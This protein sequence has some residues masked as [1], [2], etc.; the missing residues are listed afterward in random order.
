MVIRG[1][2]AADSAELVELLVAAELAVRGV[3]ERGVAGCLARSADT[4]FVAVEEGALIGAALACFNGFHLFLSHLA[5]AA[6]HRRRGVGA[7][8][9]SA[10]VERGRALGAA[11]IIADAWLSSAPF[12]QRLGYRVP[13]AVFLIRDL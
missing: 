10:V 7:A 12:F 1:A 8:L 2:S 9:H 11:G 5:V 6:P 13:G 3:A 4:C